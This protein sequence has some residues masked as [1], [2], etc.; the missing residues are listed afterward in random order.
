MDKSD[1]LF[2]EFKL[3][4]RWQKL[5]RDID[6]GARNGTTNISIAGGATTTL[7]A[8]GESAG[9]DQVELTSDMVC[10]TVTGSGVPTLVLPNPVEYI[11]VLFVVVVAGSIHLLAKHTGSGDAMNAVGVKRCVSSGTDWYIMTSEENIIKLSE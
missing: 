1:P 4:E 3:A 11:G 9:A 10:V 6:T 2:R 5:R 7:V 8:P